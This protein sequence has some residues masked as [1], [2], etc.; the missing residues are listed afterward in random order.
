MKFEES[1]IEQR[2]CFVGACKRMYELKIIY[3]NN[4]NPVVLTLPKDEAE[5]LFDTLT[6]GLGKLRTGKA[7]FNVISPRKRSYTIDVNEVASVFL[8][9][10]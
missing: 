3:K 8:N 6:S 10:V 9:E 7:A 5:S 1:T 4:E 2:K